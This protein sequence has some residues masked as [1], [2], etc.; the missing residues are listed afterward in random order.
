MKGLKVK[1]SKF[2]FYIN[3]NNS[4]QSKES[5][6]GQFYEYFCY[7]ELVQNGDNIKIVKANYVERQS[8]GNFTHSKD[9]KIIY[10]SRG[11]FI[12]EFDVLGIKENTIYWWEITRS[13]KKIDNSGIN[14]KMALLEKV[15]DK[16]T[17]S[18]CLIIP[19]VMDRNINF[20]YKIIAEPDYDKYF[21]EGYF[22]F[23][24]KI[25][26]CI[27]LSELHKLSSDY[28]YI[29]DVIVTSYEYY[30]NKNIE[31][32]KTNCLIERLYD[33]NSIKDLK[34]MYYNIKQDKNGWIEI[35]NEEIFMDGKRLYKLG[36]TKFEINSLL[37]RLKY[38][39]Q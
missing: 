25:K 5:L 13:R 31:M 38:R 17:I 2:D 16:S 12:A 3:N 35:V 26:E 19:F 29:D 20:N 28:D 18:F 30:S 1:P 24:K 6:K 37:E 27:P 7:N 8:A 21:S 22:K 39:L 15:F 23:N 34:F 4:I 36:K 9:G 10:Y 14:R 32:I 33:I 11:L